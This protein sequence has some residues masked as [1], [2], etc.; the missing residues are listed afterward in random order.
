M[1]LSKQTREKTYGLKNSEFF[2]LILPFLG[3]F[4]E[5]LQTRCSNHILCPLRIIEAMKV[6]NIAIVSQH[7]ENHFRWVT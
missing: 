1:T 5:F 2:I 6:L 4:E 3:V 7:Y